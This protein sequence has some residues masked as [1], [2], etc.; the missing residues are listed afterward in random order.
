MSIHCC[1]KRPCRGITPKKLYTSTILNNVR[2]ILCLFIPSSTNLKEVTFFCQNEQLGMIDCWWIRHSYRALFLGICG[3]G[4]NIEQWRC[5]HCINSMS[6]RSVKFQSKKVD[7]FFRDWFAGLWIVLSCWPG[8]FKN[9]ELIHTLHTATLKPC[10]VLS[11]P[12]NASPD[13]IH[14]RCAVL[15][16][17][18]T[19]GSIPSICSDW[20]LQKKIQKNGALY[21][22]LFFK[23]GCQCGDWWWA[24]S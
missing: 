13:M 16:L 9:A 17:K 18:S 21:F 22:T 7:T 4:A 11:V 12:A 6:D 23:H 1:V 3:L 5:Q 15:S 8:N 14:P 2:W 19:H 20:T 10:R 24:V